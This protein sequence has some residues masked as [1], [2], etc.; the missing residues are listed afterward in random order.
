MFSF[1]NGSSE[2]EDASVMDILLAGA[3]GFLNGYTFGALGMA[4]RLFTH[5]EHK[6]NLLKH[7]SD[8]SNEFD[9]LDYLESIHKHKD[10]IIDAVKDNFIEELINPMQEQIHEIR[11]S[12][13]DKEKQLNEAKAN[14]VRLK[15]NKVEIENQLVEIL[16]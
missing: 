2:E 4:K 7:I 6:K 10:E 13:E 5:G 3:F 8:I 12:K 9:P 1:D 15:T 14:L 16:K 11:S